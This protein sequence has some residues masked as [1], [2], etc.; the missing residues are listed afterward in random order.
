MSLWETILLADVNPNQ[1]PVPEGDYTFTLL[2]A[3]PNDFNP[4]K[5]NVSAVISNECDFTGRR[6]RFSYPDPQE[7]DWSART[8]KRLEIALGVDS[9][10]GESTI[11]F[12]NRAGSE[13]ARFSAPIKE[14]TYK[15]RETGED[16]T[17]ND[18]DI[19]KVTAAI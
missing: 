6:I 1:E 8:V 11:E 12:L 19:F 10:P 5:L 14:V 17:K 18:V 4:A 16:I 7:F 9:L 15:H 2:G 13:G 3:A